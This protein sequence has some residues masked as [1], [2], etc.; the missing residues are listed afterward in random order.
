MS[1]G[2]MTYCTSCHSWVGA[3]GVHDADC[4]ERAGDRA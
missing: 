1:D 4:P 3:T 2:D